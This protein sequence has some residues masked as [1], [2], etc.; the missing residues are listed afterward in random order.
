MRKGSSRRDT[1]TAPSPAPDAGARAGSFLGELRRRNV[2]RVAGLYLVAAWLVVQV[3][4]T[5]LPIFGTPPWVLQTLVLLL[6]LGFIPALVVSWVYE[7][8]PTGLK[9]EAD[10][11]RDAGIVAQTAR[12]LDI[13]VIMLL[14]G[15]GGLMVWQAMRAPPA[16]AAPDVASQAAAP[17]GMPAEPAAAAPGFPAKSVAVLPFADFSAN[18]DAAWFADGLSEEILNALA[19]TPDLQVAAR[20][21]SFRFRESDLSVPEIAAELGVAHVLEGSVRS[22]PG[23][24]RVTAQLIRA[25]DGFHVW[26][27]NYDRDAADVIGIQEDLATQIAT[28]MRTTMDPAALADMATVG[29]RSVDAYQAFLRGVALHSTFD[30]DD[31]HAS[32][33]EFEKARALDPGFAAAQAR[34]AA[35]WLQQ[36]DPTSN[37][38]A[39]VEGRDAADVSARFVERIDLA[40]A[41]AAGDLDRLDYREMRAE[42][43]LA[44]RDSI[45]ILRQ[46]LAARPDDREAHSN[47]IDML[48]TVRDDA[49]ARAALATIWSKA[50]DR[51]EYA[52]VHVN[53]AHRVED[54]AQAADEAWRLARRWP[55]SVGMQYQAHRALL[56]ANRVDDA[57]EVLARF[58]ALP[59]SALARSILPAARQAC[60]EGRRAEVE[61]YLAE[62]DPADVP[63]RWHLLLLLGRRDEAG[64]LLQ[65]YERD[66]NTFALAGFLVYRVFDPRPYP[67]LMRVLERE[68][69]TVGEPLALPFACPPAGEV[70][71]SFRNS[72]ERSRS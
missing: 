15:I 30:V 52:I 33:E 43:D 50:L 14:L 46:L 16:A 21:S 10:V 31:Y 35:Y 17:G 39:V 5:L 59:I 24:I 8:T 12:R 6:A 45:A 69:V 11:S 56:W 18:R 7:F 41:H 42:H 51:L 64:A 58:E 68:G 22:T 62:S 61:R 28:A 44:L 38:T 13:A 40:I 20:T 32:Y 49:A 71:S 36:L 4:E 1:A 26:S 47:L 27:Q 60:A 53:H 70:A 54:P 72:A 23:R 66:G 9:R 3:A 57:R 63:T 29:T 65:A 34:A 37:F 2:I 67:S 19:R 55:D 25:A 48:S